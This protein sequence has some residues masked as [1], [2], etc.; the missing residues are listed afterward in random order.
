MGLCS[1]DSSPEGFYVA[2]SRDRWFDG[3]NQ[4]SQIGYWV[5]PAD[6]NSRFIS[7]P[8]EQWHHVGVR[9]GADGISFRLGGE[10]SGWASGPAGDGYFC[11]ALNATQGVRFD[12]LTLR[13][14]VPAEPGVGLGSEEARP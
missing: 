12:N 14:Y 8:I 4:A 9:W 7:Y 1:D 5:G 11:F 3:D 6:T 2:A 13:R 10:Q